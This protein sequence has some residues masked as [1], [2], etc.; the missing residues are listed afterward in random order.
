MSPCT[1]SQ[2][3][4]IDQSKEP[5]LSARKPSQEAPAAEFPKEGV[6]DDRNAKVLQDASTYVHS[7]NGNCDFSIE[8]HCMPVSESGLLSLF[9]A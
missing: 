9:S 8:I 4:Q 6:V 5:E 1:L 3:I 2:E 7:C